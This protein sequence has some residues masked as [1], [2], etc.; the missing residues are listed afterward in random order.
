MAELVAWVNG[1]EVGHFTQEHRADGSLFSFEYLDDADADH[2]VSLTMIPLP[3]RRCFDLRQFPPAFDMILPEGQRRQRIEAARKIVRTDDFA[4]LGYVGGNPVN[5]VRFL[6]PEADPGQ[7]VA[8]LPSPKEIANC[9]AGQ[10]LFEKLMGEVDLRQGIAGVQP[11]VLGAAQEMAR[12]MSPDLRQE[13]GNTHILKASTAA[14]PYLAV[15]EFICL[16]VFESAGLTVPSVTLSADGELLLVERFDTLQD[17]TH[18][19]FEEVAVLMGETSVTKYQRDY[20][21]MV[22][23]LASFI[24]FQDEEEMRRQVTTALVL[25]WLLGNGDAHLKNFGVLYHDDL[26]VQ[27]APFYDVVSTLVYIPE[28]VPA[29]A[30][31]FEWYSKAW[32]PR[33]RVEEFARDYGKLTAA[34]TARMI[35]RC[36]AAV[37]EGALSAERFG[38]Q[39]RGF[40]DL[41]TRLAALWRERRLAFAP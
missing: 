39:I 6:P 32:W 36:M 34:E 22:E 2:L 10:A 40:A 7:D 41:G 30:L 29:L 15:N 26:D 21:S 27:L 8:P 5:R 23:S 17:G 33:A 35:D 31:S 12:K 4:L 9:S 19:G 11:K 16:K 20:G 3:D 18:L 28:D 14:F 37:E 1:R 24:E 25:N 13:R 38:R